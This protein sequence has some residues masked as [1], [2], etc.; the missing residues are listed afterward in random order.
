MLASG[1]PSNSEIATMA[2]QRHRR[3]YR[4]VPEASPAYV[5]DDEAAKRPATAL[6][7]NLRASI[8]K[9]PVKF[10]LRV[11]LAAADDPTT[12]A[13]KVWPDS[14]PNVEL[15][16]IAITRTLDT[17]RGRERTPLHANQPDEGNRRF[18]RSDPEHAYRSLWR[19]LRPA[20]KMSSCLPQCQPIREGRRFERNRTER[21]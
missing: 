10:Q 4:I 18:G 2:A 6:A 9:G 12:D 20:H 1:L 8:E 19:I 15:G 17:K 13:T 16:E 11:Q 3:C 7:D 5:S 21:R 14:R